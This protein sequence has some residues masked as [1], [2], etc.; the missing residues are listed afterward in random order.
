MGSVCDG[1]LVYDVQAQNG[2]VFKYAS[3][4]CIVCTI[5]PYS[6]KE[7][8]LKHLIIYETIAFYEFQCVYCTYKMSDLTETQWLNKETKTFSIFLPSLL[9]I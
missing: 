9:N 3:T 4:C 7:H 1:H 8:C 5:V 6:Y 2:L